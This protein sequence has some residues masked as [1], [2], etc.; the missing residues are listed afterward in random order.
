M[1][2]RQAAAD[3]M[4]VLGKDETETVYMLDQLRDIDITPPACAKFVEDLK[5]KVEEYRGAF[6]I[7]YKQLVWLRAIFDRVS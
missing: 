3:W 5:E 6:H 1:R 7:S 2:W 4:D